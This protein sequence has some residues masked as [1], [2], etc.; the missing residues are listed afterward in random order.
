MKTEVKCLGNTK[1]ELFTS[2]HYVGRGH[3]KP[4][5]IANVTCVLRVHVSGSC[6]DYCPCD[7]LN[8]RS[9]HRA[10]IGIEVPIRV[11]AP[12]FVCHHWLHLAPKILIISI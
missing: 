3:K 2:W 4:I 8:Q 7:S 11:R 5:L 6:N 1:G 9:G 10:E 12:H